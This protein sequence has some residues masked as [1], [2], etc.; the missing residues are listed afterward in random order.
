MRIDNLHNLFVDE[1]R[2]IYSAEK[3][4]VDALPRMVRAASTSDLQDAFNQHLE[5]TRRH[6]DRLD[7]IFNEL[8]AQPTGVEC[9][10]MQGLIEEG[11][12]VINS[13]GDSQVKDAALIGAAQR[14]EHYEIAS[15]GTVR[16]YAKELGYDEAR[17][18]LQKTLD[19]EGQTNKK[20]TKLAEGG[21]LG[22]GINERAAQR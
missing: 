8:G 22:R 4:L 19:E 9:K 3:M 21:L 1:L 20:L 15:Y 10:G 14:I 6:V 5:Q 17:D 11:N 16:T 2:D 12:E 7:Q 18:T 13:Q